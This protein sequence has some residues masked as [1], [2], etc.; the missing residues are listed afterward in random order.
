MKQI[1]TLIIVFI[2]ISLNAK[3][4]EIFIADTTEV[5]NEKVLY[6]MTSDHKNIYISM[7]TTD[8]R[9][10]MLMLRSGVTVYFDVKGKKNRDVYIKYPLKPAY[11]NNKSD[12][13][14]KEN[15][16]DLN[17]LISNLPKEAEYN[18][19]D[20]TQQFHVD[21]N[22][23]N[24]VL[25][26]AYN[27]KNDL[28]TYHLTVPKSNISED[29]KIDL[30]K[31]AIGVVAGRNG[32]VNQKKKANS[33]SS[34]MRGSGSGGGRGKGRGNKSGNASHAPQNNRNSASS[35]INFWFKAT[36]NK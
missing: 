9:T 14:R 33:K 13:S 23:L 24:V 27:R 32:D 28:L 30:S 2:S 5:V 7:S 16:L 11:L 18:N 21:L 31:L 1:V 4:G 3:S 35:A 10:M 25:S 19:F 15:K 29:E 8:K 34:G 36:T 17:H 26:F 12:I 22:S 20:N 6:S